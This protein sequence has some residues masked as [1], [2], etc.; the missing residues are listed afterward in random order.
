VS[1]AKRRHVLRHLRAREEAGIVGTGPFNLAEVLA[2]VDA[3][4]LAGHPWAEGLAVELAR[5]GQRWDC[6]NC[7][8]VGEFEREDGEP[9]GCPWC[10]RTGHNIHATLPWP[11]WLRRKGQMMPVLHSVLVSGDATIKRSSNGWPPNTAFIVASLK[12]AGWVSADFSATCESNGER[13]AE[14]RTREYPRG[15]HGAHDPQLHYLRRPRWERWLLTGDNLMPRWQA[16]EHRHNVQRREREQARRER[17]PVARRVHGDT[18]HG[19]SVSVDWGDGEGWQD[20]TVQELLDAHPRTAFAPYVRVTTPWDG[21]TDRLTV[22][23][24]DAD[25][26]FDG[27]LPAVTIVASTPG[28]ARHWGRDERGE[29]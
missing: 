10:E 27:D 11:A 3:M 7:L 28:Q 23:L 8:G 25:E 18:D 6:D 22:S 17:V 12:P 21:P 26:P 1:Q 20:T 14:R 29:P 9:L 24:G 16:G 19:M 4:M 15:E 13:R 2:K 5:T